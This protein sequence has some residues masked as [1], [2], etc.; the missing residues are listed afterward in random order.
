MSK[1]S[2][3]GHTLGPKALELVMRD[4]L[5][6]MEELAVM[7]HYETSGDVFEVISIDP[8]EAVKKS[9]TEMN[10]SQTEK[11]INKAEVIPINQF[12]NQK[13]TKD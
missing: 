12:R 7:K 4:V 9:Q 13:N 11:S 3:S 6:G 2:I 1:K 5:G 10:D 8:S